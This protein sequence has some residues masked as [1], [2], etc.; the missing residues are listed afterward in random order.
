VL[1]RVVLRKRRG[2]RRRKVEEEDP[3]ATSDQALAPLLD[4]VP[5]RV[6]ISRD[7]STEE[8]P[9]H[10]RTEIR[11]RERSW[12]RRKKRRR[13][14]RKGGASRGQLDRLCDK[15]AKDFSLYSLVLLSFRSG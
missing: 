3:S 7:A 15:R 14:R 5:L 4:L 11:R 2:G 13:R 8:R 6:S 1:L 12:G 9:Q 10:P